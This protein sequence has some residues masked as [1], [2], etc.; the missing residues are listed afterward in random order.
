MPSSRT[1]GMNVYIE[2]VEGA[3]LASLD[4]GSDYYRSIAGPLMAAFPSDYRPL[5]ELYHGIYSFASNI[6][7]RFIGGRVSTYLLG[8]PLPLP[9]QVSFENQLVSSVSPGLFT[10][11]VLTA[12]ASTS[13]VEQMRWLR[14]AARCT[15]E[16]LR[17]HRG[18]FSLPPQ[19]TELVLDAVQ[20][21]VLTAD[22]PVTWLRR[23]G[24]T[25]EQIRQ[26]RGW[27]GV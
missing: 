20:A 19:Y 18:S 9:F 11:A 5:V 8:L 15:P 10:F 4:S 23:G 17:A 2:R 14:M 12:A 21:L 3:P 6:E 24:L 25:A 26:I 1:C 27:M 13:L 16:I 22:S 7:I